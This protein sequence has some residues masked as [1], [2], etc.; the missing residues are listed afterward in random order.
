MGRLKEKQE[1]EERWGIQINWAEYFRLRGALVR[2]QRKYRFDWTSSVVGR[3]LETFIASKGKGCG[4]YRR[5]LRGKWSRGYMENDPREI[6]ENVMGGVRVE[7][8]NRVICEM[9]YKLWTISH[10][11]AEFKNFCFRL[12]Q[13][14]LY[15]NQ[16]RA[17]FAEV[18]RWCTFCGIIKIRELGERGIGRD[19]VLYNEELMRLPGENPEHLFWECVTVNRLV[20]A[21][22]NNIAGTQNRVIDKN[23]YFTGWC[24]K[25]MDNTVLILVSVHMVKYVLYKYK[26][27]Q[28]IPT[29]FTLREEFRGMMEGLLRFGRWREKLM[30][31]QETLRGIMLEN[32]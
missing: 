7:W 12:V 25:S 31:I 18:G 8:E 16:Q 20:N 4:R 22:F 10:L 19:N 27:R 14:R 24:G 21:F 23:K 6:T 9:N 26:I 29:F 11:H 1:L 13:G 5:V 32:V 2:I 3:S 30:E 28:R 15:L 17:R